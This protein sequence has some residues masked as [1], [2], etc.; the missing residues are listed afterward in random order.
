[1][2]PWQISEIASFDPLLTRHGVPTIPVLA[3][4]SVG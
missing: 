2:R 4:R 1:M 3:N